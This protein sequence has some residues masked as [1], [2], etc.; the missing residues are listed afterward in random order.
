MRI[1]VFDLA[2]TTGWANG[3]DR[4]P[5]TYGSYRI[6]KSGDDLGLFCADF[7]AWYGAKLAELRP[8]LVAYESPI[9]RTMKR[10]DPV[11]KRWTEIPPNIVTLR[12]LYTLASLAELGARD[13]GIECE[14]IHMQSARAHFL[15]R[16]NTPKASAAI[17]K[18]VKARCMVRGWKPKD[19]NEADA[20]CLLDYAR[21]CHEPGWDIQTLDLF[22]RRG[23]A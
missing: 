18:A 1:A 14:E 6:T 12:K 8:N 5:P 20:L 10:F 11:K 23:A 17:E 21:A 19:D 15:G 4:Q 9:L 7:R 3:N 16:G 2:T 22:Q 13:A